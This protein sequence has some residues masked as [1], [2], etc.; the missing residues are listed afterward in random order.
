MRVNVVA[1][2]SR[3][4]VIGQRLWDNCELS[5]TGRLVLLCRLDVSF[6]KTDE[7]FSHT[8]TNR[9]QWLGF[10]S[11]MSTI[12]TRKLQTSLHVSATVEG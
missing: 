3:L 12:R 4:S 7:N 9:A 6:R 8:R 11:S 5:N 2:A 1:A 10:E